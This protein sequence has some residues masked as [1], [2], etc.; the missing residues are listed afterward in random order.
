[1]VAAREPLRALRRASTIIVTR[2][3]ASDT[4]VAAV[5]QAVSAAAPEVPVAVASLAAG[6]L[7]TLAGDERPLASL[8]GARV[9]GIAGIGWPP[10]FFAQLTAAG[11]RVDGAP[12]PDHHRFTVTDVAQIRRYAVPGAIAVCTLKDAVKL[13][14]LWP[15]EAERLWYVS[16]RVEFEFGVDAVLAALEMLGRIRPAHTR[17]PASHRTD[18]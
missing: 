2:K 12:Y 5:R 13:E 3:A 16:Q 7:R 11:A 9:V 14:G 10:A 4:V 15:R 18:S 6:P 17:F 8:R 1:V